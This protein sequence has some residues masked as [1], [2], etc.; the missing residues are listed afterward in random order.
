RG[1]MYYRRAL[2]L[3]SFLER[4]TL[5]VS[6]PT[7]QGFEFSPEARA[8][9]DLKF[10]YVVSCQIYGQQKQQKKPE[11]ADIALLLKR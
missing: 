5:G 2:M 8:Q 3:Q 4:R 7:T 1:M 11:A 9:A 6:I 10:T